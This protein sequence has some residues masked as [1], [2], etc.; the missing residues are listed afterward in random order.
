M[1][2]IKITNN[3]IKKNIYDLLKTRPTG[4]TRQSSSLPPNAHPI[5]ITIWTPRPMFLYCGKMSK[6]V[7][8]SNLIFFHLLSHHYKLPLPVFSHCVKKLS[9]EKCN[10]VPIKHN[11]GTFVFF[12]YHQSWLRVIS[13]TRLIKIWKQ[14]IQWSHINIL[15]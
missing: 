3:I 4:T 13:I 1:N 7:I 2:H 5:L 9:T 12:K 6:N 8:R 14:D 15:L 11:I 10:D